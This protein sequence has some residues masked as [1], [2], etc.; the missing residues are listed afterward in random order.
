MERGRERA[1]VVGSVGPDEQRDPHGERRGALDRQ[2]LGRIECGDRVER[3]VEPGGEPPRREIEPAITGR[4]VVRVLG[5][6]R[7]PHREANVAEQDP[8]LAEPRAVRAE[9]CLADRPGALGVVAAPVVSP[10]SS[11]VCAR[12]N[13]PVATARSSWPNAAVRSARLWSWSASASRSLPRAR[14]AA[15]SLSR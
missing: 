11:S 4:T 12:W 5:D 3:D 15:A 6:L 2:R 13:R 14:F 8:Q 10:A 9:L 7:E 1:S